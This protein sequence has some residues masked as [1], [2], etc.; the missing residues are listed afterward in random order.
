[1]NFAGLL[2]LLVAH[3][4]TGRGILQL[5]R[6]QLDN[7]VTI[8]CSFIISV[9]V[10][11][12]APCILQL[13][14]M[15]ITGTT[16]F[17]AVSV[18]TVISSIP[19]FLNFK[20]PR[21]QKISMPKLYEWPAFLVIIFFIVMSLWRCYYMPPY[22][23]DML[24]GPELIAEYTVR[25]HTMINS[26]FNIDLSTSNNYHKSPFVTSLQIIYKLLVFQYGQLWLSILFLS[27][28]TFIYTLLRSRLHPLL[29]GFFLVLFTTVPELYAYTFVILYDYSNMVFFFSGFYFLTMYL[30]NDRQ[31]DLAFSIFLFGLATYIRT[32]SLILIAMMT[33]LLMIHL[34][35]KKLPLKTSALRLLLFLVVPAAFYYLCINVFVAHFVPIKMNVA[36]NI[37]PNLG[38]LSVLTQRLSDIFSLLIFSFAGSE[39]YGYFFFIFT[40]ILCLDIIWMRKFNKEAVYALYGVAVIYFGLGF[41]GYL[42][43]LADL[44]NT[45]KRGFFKA[46]PMMLLYMANSGAILRLSQGIKNWEMG[47]QHKAKPATVK[48]HHKTQ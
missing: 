39:Y 30:Q 19:L 33:P 18:F 38:D 7:V 36:D 21:F 26:V 41:I 34:Y 4:I 25:E 44:G 42:L 29:A 22:S 40:A 47:S 6:L 13:L 15:P 5:F 9:P 43:P 12:L 8:C 31:N 27:F 32:E 10:L 37:N 17:A 11:S 48:P 46:I 3:Y 1:M 24:S 23:R 20:M 28:T 45:T 2:F 16:V 14:K 35:K